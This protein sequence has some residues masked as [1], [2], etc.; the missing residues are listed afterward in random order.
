MMRKQRTYMLS[1]TVSAE[2][3]KSNIF[4][5]VTRYRVMLFY[6]RVTSQRGVFHLFL[7]VIL[8]QTRHKKI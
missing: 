3:G 2:L 7:R 5:R 1:I 6:R 8:I 4:Q